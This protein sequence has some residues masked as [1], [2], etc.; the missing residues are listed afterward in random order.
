MPRAAAA[1]APSA[2]FASATT[3][4]SVGIVAADLGLVGV[5]V[6]QPRRRNREREARIPRARVRF[7]EARADGEDQIR[8]A[9]LLVGD[10]R[11]PEAGLP[12][13]QRMILAQAA[14][15]HQRVRDRQLE[16]F[17]ERRE[18]RRRARREHAAAGV[19]HRALGVRQRVDDA[20]RGRR[21]DRSAAPSPPAPCWN[22]STG[23]SAEKMSIGT[24]T[25]TGPGRPA[26][27]RWNARSMMRGRSATRSTR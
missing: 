2:S 18:L 25:S 13:Q 16:R 19:E 7:G 5:D 3:P 4:S 6:N 23:R 22:A 27:A 8:G 14:L 17:G 24:S 12:E 21:I 10:R 15:A 26:C 9:A 11:A 1:S 20:R